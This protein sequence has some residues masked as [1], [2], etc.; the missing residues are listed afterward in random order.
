MG[1]AAIEILRASASFISA[2][3]SRSRTLRLLNIDEHKAWREFQHWWESRAAGAVPSRTRYSDAPR[4]AQLRPAVDDRIIWSIDMGRSFEQ[5]AP[6][7]RAVLQLLVEGESI[8]IRAHQ[9][10]TSVRTLHRRRDA[11][12]QQ[13]AAIRGRYADED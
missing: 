3:P 8:A 7:H 1:T 4:Q 6:L 5:L 10:G 13:L 12:L 11:A 2:P 9:M